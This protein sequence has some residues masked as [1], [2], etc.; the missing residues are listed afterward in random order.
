M[1]EFS[2]RVLVALVV[3]AAG[4]GAAMLTLLVVGPPL[5]AASVPQ[6]EGGIVEAVASGL[7]GILIGGALSVVGAYVVAAAATLVALRTTGCPRPHLA[8][9]MCLALSPMWMAALSTL[10]LDMAGLVVLIGL[11][12]G[13]VRL[14][15][16]YV[17]S[18]GSR[19]GEVV[20]PPPEIW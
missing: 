10:N 3:A 17:E 15:F 2:R 6:T 19:T 5:I 1:E 11:L 20:P 14:A 16:G 9:I 18:P 13:A 7:V 12:P 4:P 8:W